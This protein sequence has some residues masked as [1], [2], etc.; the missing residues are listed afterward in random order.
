MHPKMGRCHPGLLQESDRLPLFAGR[1]Q[2][3]CPG[4]GLMHTGAGGGG[5]GG[6]ESGQPR[7]DAC[8]VAAPPIQGDQHVLGGQQIRG[9]PEP[10]GGL[11]VAPGSGGVARDQAKGGPLAVGLVESRVHHRRAVQP[12]ARVGV[13]S[14]DQIDPAEMHQAH[15]PVGLERQRAPELLGG[16]RVVVQLPQGHAELVVRLRVGWIEVHRALDGL[17]NAGERDGI[18]EPEERAPGQPPVGQSRIQSH[19]ALRRLPPASEQALGRELVIGPA[20]VEEE[21]VSVGQSGKRRGEAGVE[22][23]GFGVGLARA[24]E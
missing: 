17:P 5:R 16:R 24:G 11:G 3:R 15:R 12:A 22:P 23:A 20:P 21:H 4:R 1:D 2:E 13:A 19:R 7:P 6:A 8:A 14:P 18:A 10:D 9:R